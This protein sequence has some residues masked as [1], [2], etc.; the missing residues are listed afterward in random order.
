MRPTR[1]MGDWGNG[2]CLSGGG[3]YDIGVGLSS[4]ESNA[5]STSGTTDAGSPQYLFGTTY[6][7]GSYIAAAAGNGSGNAGSGVGLNISTTAIIG[8]VVAALVF[9]FFLKRR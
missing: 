9:I 6:G 5:A 1:M 7:P 4:S 8:V 3:G 2:C